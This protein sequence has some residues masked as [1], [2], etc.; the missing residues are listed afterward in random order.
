MACRSH[1]RRQRRRHTAYSVD[2]IR[3]ATVDDVPD[4]VRLVAELAAYEK[5][6]DAATGTEQ[7]YLAAL[8]P[9]WTDPLVSAIVADVDG[10]IV[11]MAIWFV[12][13]STWTA[14]HG[15]WLEDLFVRPE[16]RGSGIG[17]DLMA[18]IARVCVERGYP[19]MEWTVLDW[20]TPAIEVY[21]HLGAEPMSKWTTQRLTGAALAELAGK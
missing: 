6:P 18:A 13:F 16:H 4:L 11:G 5:E 12:T 10:D 19:R 9:E 21:H 2:V 3:P 14:Q 17:R 15:A 1:P 20:N 7:D 8:F